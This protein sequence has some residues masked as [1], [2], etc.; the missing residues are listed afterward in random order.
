MTSELVRQRPVEFLTIETTEP[1]HWCA[2]IGMYRI[3]FQALEHTA[4]TVTDDI[5]SET[6]G[7]ALIAKD[8]IH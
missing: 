7:A 8:R 6:N 4:M 1:H 3:C 5:S 2:E